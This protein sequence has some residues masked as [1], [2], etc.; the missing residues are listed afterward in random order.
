M[1]ALLLAAMLAG[2]ECEDA[3]PQVNRADAAIEQSDFEGAAK[4]LE[5]VEHLSFRC[6]NVMVAAGRAAF[7]KGDY[8]GANMYSD[9]AVRTAPES[10]A[11]L[12][13][14]GRVLASSGQV[15]QARDLFER[16]TKLDPNNAEAHFEYGRTLDRAKRTP[17]AM[18]EFERTTQLRPHDP[19]AYDYLAL[20]LE[21]LGE[22][23]RAE[24]AYAA[25]LKVNDGPG[26]D[27]LLD[28]NYG[29]FLMKLNR[30]AESKMHLDR[31]VELAPQVRA[32]H[33]DRAKLNLRFGKLAEARRD[34][35][36]AL[37]LPDPNGFILDLQI[38]NLLATVCTRLDDTAAAQKYID[39]VRQ[40]PI[41]MRSRER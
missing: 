18:A 41:P 9:L 32:V 22:T 40:T 33:Y 17:E 23:S 2:G 16:A 15:G 4:L 8:R 24:A 36:T 3:Q 25:G 19:R 35:E 37:S 10:G 39:L 29:K 13:L 6:V 7:G 11:A 12:L 31:A 20:N 14:R 21:R 5:Q 26:F 27:S 38:Y 28:Y 1:M 30:L 34:A